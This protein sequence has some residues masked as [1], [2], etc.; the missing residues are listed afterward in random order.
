MLILKID[1]VVR[2]FSRN[3]EID[4]PV[5][6]MEGDEHDWEDNSAVL[7][8]I[9]GSHTKQSCWWLGWQSWGADLGWKQ[10]GTCICTHVSAV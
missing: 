6:E 1:S 9:T 7:V 3:T 5:H 4:H 10:W 8:N 2:D